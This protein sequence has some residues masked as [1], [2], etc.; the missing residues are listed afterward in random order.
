[1]DGISATNEQI[2][3]SFPRF[4]GEG[5]PDFI[6]DFLGTKTRTA[7][8]NL[9]RAERS[10]TVEDYPFPYN[11]HAS[12][13]EW[14]GALRSVLDAKSEYVAVE[15]GAG[16]A[17]W[18]ISMAFAARSRGIWKFRLVGV[19]ASKAH[20]EFARTHFLDNGFDPDAHTL[21]HG[22]AGP[23]D[24]YGHFP[25]LADPTLD[26]GSP[27]Q[28]PIEL[29][30]KQKWKN[31][32]KWVLGRPISPVSQ[33]ME[34]I[35]CYSLPT[36]LAPFAQV[37]LLHI[38]IQGGERELIPAARRVVRQKVRWLVIGTHG[39]DIEQALHD[40]LQDGPWE[41]ETEENC[42][43]SLEGGQLVLH[44]DGCQVWRNRR[45]VASTFHAAA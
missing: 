45:L 10:G 23:K 25:V 1:M 22:I 17:P 38:D 18:L 7:Y 30:F 6:I 5:V 16:W 28:F 34:R 44:R 36:L 43:V 11:F 2:I 39:R 20:C 37:D 42:H 31:R 3:R 9:N 29:G 27:A 19:E 13:L 21:L 24:G 14:S 35:R 15:L 26:Y 12:A 41:L 32:I 4:R 8:I 40:E 33:G